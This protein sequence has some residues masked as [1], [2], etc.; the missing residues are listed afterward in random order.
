[1]E[2]GRRDTGVMDPPKPQCCSDLHSTKAGDTKP[3]PCPCPLPP[4]KPSNPL[5][6]RPDVRCARPPLQLQ[7]SPPMPPRPHSSSHRVPP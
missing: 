2:G 6:P 3:R 7:M 1:M 4:A 5:I